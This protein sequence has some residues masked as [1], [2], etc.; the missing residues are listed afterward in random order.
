MLMSPHPAS[1]VASQPQLS[2]LLPSGISRCRG[3]LGNPTPSIPFQLCCELPMHLQVR[4]WRPQSAAGR[5]AGA[6]VAGGVAVEL[7]G[8]AVGAAPADRSGMA[9]SLS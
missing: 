5:D 3:R 1:L 8:P 9:L 4:V 2:Q 7:Q 6:G